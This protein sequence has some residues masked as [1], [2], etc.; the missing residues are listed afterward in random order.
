MKV[1]VGAAAADRDT[2]PDRVP[3]LL[4]MQRELLVQA[5]SG[6]ETREVLE[7]LVELIEAY[8]PEAVGSVLL[9]EPETRTLAD[10]RRPESSDRLQ[11]RDRRSADR[12]RR[13][14]VRDRGCLQQDGHRRRH[15]HRSSLGCVPR[16][17]AR[18]MGCARAGRHRSSTALDQ[19]IG[20]FALYYDAVRRPTKAT[21]S[22][23]TSRQG[24]RAS[25]SSANE[26]LLRRRVRRPSAPRSTAGIGHS[27]S[28]FRS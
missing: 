18:R 17:R 27:W 5:A 13:R 28:S 4:Q 6:V 24:S 12:R 9:V 2:E 21:W 25:C 19:V 26:L 15:R 10:T 22:W 3:A 8:V 7:L 1:I 20:T 14:L 16:A 11:R 23:W